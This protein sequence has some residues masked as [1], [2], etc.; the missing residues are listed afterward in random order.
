MGC[1]VELY[2]VLGSLLLVLINRP[3][4]SSVLLLSP[5]RIW[6]GFWLIPMYLEACSLKLVSP[7]EY[8][9][10]LLTPLIA[11]FLV[12]TWSYRKVESRRRLF[13]HSSSLN[14]AESCSP[15]NRRC[16]LVR[17]MHSQ[18]VE[19]CLSGLSNQHKDRFCI[20]IKADGIRAECIEP[21]L[22]F[23]REKYWS[24]SL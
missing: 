16:C 3:V 4:D 21:I 20:M 10:L 5:R 19:L 1:R 2:D 22:L 14:A 13:H 6:S 24:S 7:T 9:Y 8:L 15:A 12:E 17:V 11:Y 23:T 18:N